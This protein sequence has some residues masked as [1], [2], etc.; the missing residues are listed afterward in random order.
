MKYRVKPEQVPVIVFLF[1]VLSASCR[2][3]G[4]FASGRLQTAAASPPTIEQRHEVSPASS[5]G[6]AATDE[7]VPGNGSQPVMKSV[8]DFH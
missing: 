8:T 6:R 7:S 3:I 5:H 1:F 2:G 4:E